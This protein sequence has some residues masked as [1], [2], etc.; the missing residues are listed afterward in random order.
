MTEY[1]VVMKKSDHGK[2]E[3]VRV[4]DGAATR[5][6][7]LGLEV[8]DMLDDLVG[9]SDIKEKIRSFGLLMYQ[10]SSKASC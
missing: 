6:L 7:L 8:E 9:Q 1:T 5:E 2:H 10:E 4:K 3:I